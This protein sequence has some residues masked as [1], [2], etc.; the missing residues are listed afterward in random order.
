MTDDTYPP[1]L[2]HRNELWRGAIGSFGLD[3]VVLPNGARREMAV[4]HHPGAAAVVPFLDDDTVLLLRQYRHAAGC[5]LWEVPAGKLDDGEDPAVCVARELEEETGHVAG[6]IEPLGRV[7]TAPGFTDEV[8]H[9]F[10]AYALRD[11]TLALE[12]GE[13]I[14]T[15]PVAFA[16]ALAMLDRGEIT[17]AKTVAAL[18]LAERRRR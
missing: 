18:T 8:V 11:G 4:I 1:G 12:A 9:L 7:H 10:A 13:I 16:E 2:R 15:Q 6:R 3:D 14:E 5:T 17:D